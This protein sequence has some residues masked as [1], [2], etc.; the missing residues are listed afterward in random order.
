MSS[1][2]PTSKL[3]MEMMCLVFIICNQKDRATY[4]DSDGQNHLVPQQVSKL[5]NVTPWQTFI[6]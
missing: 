3:E 1:P 5:G 4:G 2:D 6:Y